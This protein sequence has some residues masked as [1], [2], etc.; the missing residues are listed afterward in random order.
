MVVVVAGVEFVGLVVV[1]DCLA[2]FA[3]ISRSLRNPT[4]RHG[5]Y[6]MTVPV[7][8]PARSNRTGRF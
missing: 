3:E 4:H 1:V 5:L 6:G 7:A 2:A 8:R